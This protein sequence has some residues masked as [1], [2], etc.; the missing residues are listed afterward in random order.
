MDT[1][2]SAVEGVCHS[3]PE[4]AKNEFKNKMLG[5]LEADIDK[6]SEYKEWTKGV[7]WEFGKVISSLATKNRNDAMYIMATQDI[8][9]QHLKDIDIKSFIKKIR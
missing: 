8:V 4:T 7:V 3:W 6:Y 2:S 5:C 1:I 9:A